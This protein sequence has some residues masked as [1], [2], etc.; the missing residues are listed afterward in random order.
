MSD[1]IRKRKRRERRSTD[2]GL[3]R[4][5]TYQ[6][7][8]ASSRSGLPPRSP[9]GSEGD[10]VRVRRQ[11]PDIRQKRKLQRTQP[12]KPMKRAQINTSATRQ[13]QRRQVERTNNRTASRNTV[14]SERAM[15]RS[16]ATVV[17]K[18]PIRRK[19]AERNSSAVMVLVGAFLFIFVLGYLAFYTIRT[20]SVTTIKNETVKLGTVEIPYSAEGVIVRNEKVFNALSAGTVEYNCADNEKVKAG[21]VICSVKNMENM[22]SMESDLEKIDEELFD[23]QSYR[24]ELSLH[25]ED[26]KKYNTTIAST[27][28]SFSGEL[29]TGNVSQLLKLKE[30]V[31]DLWT[32]RNTLILSDN[33]GSAQELAG[34]RKEKEAEIASQISSVVNDKGGIISY[35]ADGYEDKYNFEIISQ[36]SQIPEEEI[37]ENTET[38]N[39]VKSMVETGS[40]VF[41]TVYSNEWYIVS[42]I[43]TQYVTEWEQGD[44]V[45]VYITGK[46]QSAKSEKAYVYNITK[47]DKQSYV[48]LAMNK[49]I[50]DYITDRYISLKVSKADEGYKILN[51]AITEQNLLEVPSEYILGNDEESQRNNIQ[52][53]VTLPGEKGTTTVDVKISADDEENNVCFIQIEYG[54]VNVGTVL[55]NPLNSSQTYTIENIITEK[56]I[57]VTNSGITKFRKINLEDSVTNDT[58]TVLS[59]EKNPYIDVYDKYAADASAVYDD[60]KTVKPKI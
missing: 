51:T 30:S 2:N 40:P 22:E 50:I 9:S 29:S 38:V 35:Y 46:T 24:D 57:Y 14:Y 11:S 37:T 45:T 15:R 5:V 10:L 17:K 19:R 1:E 49:N 53:Y 43:D 6:G 56:G 3:K 16:S 34:Q 48:V 27:V 58:H 12:I 52:P 28:D 13:Q 23:I 26:F 31:S 60:E 36:G 44:Y 21:Q 41:K 8:S 25:Y 42:Y 59:I 54:K 33:S 39:L 20:L 4:R 18:K 55:Q 32:R 7:G 47:N